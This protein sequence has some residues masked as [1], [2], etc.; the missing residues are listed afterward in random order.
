VSSA[1]VLVTNLHNLT[2]PPVRYE[3]T[4]RF[5]RPA[6]EPTAGWLRASIDGRADE[7]LRYG[8][9][10]V[11]PHVIRSIPASQGEV[12]EYQVRQTA[13]GIDVLC[14]PDGDAGEAVL[15]ERLKDALRQA[16]LN[17]P[18]ADVRL[19]QAIRRDPRT[20]KVTRFIPM[21]S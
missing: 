8:R 16:G 9:V 6:G 17:A 7:V 19:V 12:R 20:G 2:Q 18:Q 10:T 15:A 21:P 14:V 3:L 1:K 5:T 11:H 4:D 13:D